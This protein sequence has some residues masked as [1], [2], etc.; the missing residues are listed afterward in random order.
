L[1]A[2][3]NEKIIEISRGFHHSMALTDCDHVYSWG[4]N[5]CGQLGLE[6]T[7]GSYNLFK[8]RSFKDKEP[9]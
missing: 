6:Y 5:D 9:K 7:E 8:T 1:N 3:N 4:D 2:F